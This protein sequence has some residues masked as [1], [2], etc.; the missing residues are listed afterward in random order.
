MRNLFNK[1]FQC[2]VFS[3]FVLI[4]TGCCPGP[5]P[6]CKNGDED[7]IKEFRFA[8]AS[9]TR[10]CPNHIGGDREFSGNGPDVTARVSLD[11]RNSET[12][13]WA[14]LYLH[15]KETKSN[16]TEAEGTWQRKLWTAEP[17]YKIV[18]IDS[19]RSS[20]AHYT[21]TDHSL[22]KPS[23]TGGTLV[24]AFE[25]MGDTGG[26]DVGNCTADDVYMNVYFNEIFGK[27]QKL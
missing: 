22:D 10:L 14:T 24:S 4:V 19:D 7:V 6:W 5:W 8:P 2:A 20:E 26:N 21:D 15:A 17:G 23:P 16:W 18:S 3:V 12:E 11:T 1:P 27:M 25:I 13:I 9:I